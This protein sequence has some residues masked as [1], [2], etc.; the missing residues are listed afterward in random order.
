MRLYHFCLLG[1]HKRH[2]ALA[3][4]GLQRLWFMI[5]FSSF[6]RSMLLPFSHKPWMCDERRDFK[7]LVLSISHLLFHSRRLTSL[8]VINTPHRNFGVLK[9]PI[10]LENFNN[11]DKLFAIVSALC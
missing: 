2:S 8:L 6:I 9:T 5:E 7:S 11:R 10:P 1:L 4:F 3:F